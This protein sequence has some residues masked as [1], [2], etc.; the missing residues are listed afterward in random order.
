[1]ARLTIACLVLFFGTVVLAQNCSNPLGASAGVAGFTFTTPQLASGV[2]GAGFCPGTVN[3]CCN[4]TVYNILNTTFTALD[5]NFKTTFDAFD[6]ELPQFLSSLNQL[7]AQIDQITQLTPAQKSAMHKFVA[8][9]KVFYSSFGNN[10]RLCFAGILR[11]VAGIYCFACNGD[12]AQYVTVTSGG[13][14][15][16]LA[17]N[18]CN[19]MADSCTPLF[20]SLVTL[21]Q[22]VS[23]ASSALGGGAATFTNPCTPDCRTYICAGLINGGT[24]STGDV[25]QGPPSL[26]GRSVLDAEAAHEQ[27]QA[28]AEYGAYL[29]RFYESNF[30]IPAKRAASGSSTTNTYV[31][32]GGYDSYQVGSQSGMQSK[33]FTAQPSPSSASSLAPAAAFLAAVG[34]ALLF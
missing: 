15:V 10:C 29:V 28:V 8:A 13:Y 1:M 11:Y 6:Q 21:A 30:V 19:K 17:V 7:D 18:T 25:L 33:T 32:S 24:V 22:S 20:N 4:T 2:S 34:A 26:G 9:A 16:K 5:T 3:T 27:M 23:D 31:N 14:S 12:W